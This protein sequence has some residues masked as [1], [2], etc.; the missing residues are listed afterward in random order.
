[1]NQSSDS[2]SLIVRDGVQLH[3]QEW[4]IGSPKAALIIVHG[5]GEHIG[6]YDHLAEYLNKNGISVFGFDLRGHGLSE[7][8]KGHTPSHDRML[9][10][11]EEIMMYVRA[12]YND[13]PIFLFGHSM[14]G[15]IV[16]N[17]ILK[18]NV[19]ELVGAIISSPWLRTIKKIPES[20]IKLAKFVNKIFPSFQQSNGL[21]I[22]LLTYDKAVNDA[23][24]EDPLTHDQISVRMFLEFRNAGEWALK[25]AKKIKLKA[26][27]YHGSDDMITSSTASSSFAENAGNL[28]DFKTYLN[29]RHEPHNDSAQKEVFED[30]KKWITA[31]L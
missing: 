4:L 7:G 25:N 26:L 9:D 12:E 24:L 3:I 29:T 19:N 5:L 16:A 2:Y 14:G 8:K 23:Y 13:L 30:L 1:M 15:N 28:A 11:V 6:R 20:K 10:D 18:K 22:N 17:Y 31:L 21:D 27:I